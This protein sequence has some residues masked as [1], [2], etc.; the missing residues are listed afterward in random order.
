MSERKE[1]G[2]AYCVRCDERGNT[3]EM[4]P[5][6]WNRDDAEAEKPYLWVHTRCRNEHRHKAAA[7]Q[8]KRLAT[9]MSKMT[10]DEAS[11]STCDLTRARA[12]SNLANSAGELA[13]AL[14]Q[15]ETARAE[16]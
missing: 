9:G 5:L 10:K 4:E 15:R 1:D 14:R 16:L 8:L 13:G 7:A 2:Q 3:E 12:M 11:G 6:Y